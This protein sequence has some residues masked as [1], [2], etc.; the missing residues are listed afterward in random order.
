MTDVDLNVHR[1]SP[2]ADEA[3]FRRTC[4]RCSEP[5]PCPA[6][7]DDIRAEQADIIASVRSQVSDDA[8]RVGVLSLVELGVS[9]WSSTRVDAYDE[10]LGG[11]VVEIEDV[12][13]IET[14]EIERWFTCLSLGAG[15][16]VKVRRI[17]EAEVLQTGV[18]ATDGSTITK[19]VKKLAGEVHDA[20]G[21]YLDLRASE[22][23]RWQY[24]LT[25]VANLAA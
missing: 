23:V 7:R 22:R 5:W 17:A 11:V 19:L 1:A 16:A 18:Q 15:P 2:P 25:G 8:R 21:S 24:V 20:K 10:A 4:L 3:P 9:V 14:G 13:N 6:R 12:P